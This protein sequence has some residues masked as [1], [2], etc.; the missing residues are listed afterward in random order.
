MGDGERG[1]LQSDAA[2][3]SGNSAS[4]ETG[5]SSPPPSGAAVIPPGHNP[6]R[7]T[8]LPIFLV[9]FCA[10]IVGLIARWNLFNCNDYIM[11]ILAYSLLF[12]AGGIVLGGA[13]RV[14]GQF[15]PFGIPWTVDAAGGIAAAVI[16]GLLAYSMK[17]ACSFDSKIQITGIPLHEPDSNGP[18][19]TFVTVE[20]DPNVI[21]QRGANRGTLNFNFEDGETFSIIMRAYRQEGQQ[22][23]FLA[24]CEVQFTHKAEAPEVPKDEAIYWL[25]ED[26]PL[27]LS[28]D[29]GYFKLVADADRNSRVDSVQNTC[30]RGLFESANERL[31]TTTAITPL[32]IMREKIAQ[33][34]PR[35]GKLTAFFMQKKLPV[36]ADNKAVVKEAAQ[37]DTSPSNEVLTSSGTGT[38]IVLPPPTKLAKEN[39]SQAPAVSAAPPPG[40]L[41]DTS[42]RA[43]VDAFLNGDDLDKKTRQGT[44]YPNWPHINCYVLPIAERLN[45]NV[46]PLQQS[47][48]L[49][50]LINAITN[51]SQIPDDL[52]YWQSDGQNRRDFKRQ[53]PYL[54]DSDLQK[55]VDLIPS[56][57]ALVRAEGLRFVKLLPVDGLERLFKQKLQRLK[58]AG[59][60][61]LEPEKVERFAVAGVS[62]Y[63]NR[64]V[65]WLDGSA[66]S[67]I[68]SSVGADFAAGMEW[69]SDN[70]FNNRSAKPYEATLLYAK[71]I[72]ERE[73]KLSDDGNPQ[74]KATFA[75]MLAR[76]KLT[77]DSYPLRSMHIAQA[78]AFVTNIPD[79]ALSDMLKQIQQADQLTPAM[80]FDDNSPFA[81][82]PL[83]MYAGPK[84]DPSVALGINT[85]TKDGGSILLR[86]GDWY[87]VRGKEK[88]GWIARS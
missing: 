65:E 43:L 80:A 75:K 45:A 79:A 88:I 2:R 5:A 12:G 3:T 20:T 72:V 6:I 51:N 27:S 58:T 53:L 14:Q 86:L 33:V 39:I 62:L 19:K 77:E 34:G 9:V 7:E 29:T 66:D 13:L 67:T 17:P 85:S 78:L 81:G 15:K 24:A 69:A 56:D 28:F 47:R 23:R 41:K 38:Q 8:L 54:Q 10:L 68:R 50:L 64:I 74:Y 49:K 61:K 60:D 57:D 84:K 70:Y 52:Y 4:S 55:I 73:Q 1:P 22:Y 30:L 76:L 83:T 32:N 25:K 48:A 82:K 40:C 31:E 46:T 71:G 16:A 44:I 37:T 63:Y 36:P 35:R 87:F 42:I 26:S 11:L 21:I 59:H 18:V